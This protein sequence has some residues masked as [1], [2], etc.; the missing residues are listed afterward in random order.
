M[1]LE[2][3][4]LKTFLKGI[5]KTIGFPHAPGFLRHPGAFANHRIIRGA[6]P[7]GSDSQSEMRFL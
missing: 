7:Y 3:T 2:K 5:A 1:N 6:D 4:F